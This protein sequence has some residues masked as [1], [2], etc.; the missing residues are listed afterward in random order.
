MIECVVQCGTDSTV[1][2]ARSPEGHSIRNVVLVMDGEGGGERDD[3]VLELFNSVLVW[4]L[5]QG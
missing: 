5:G 2:W 3:L 1:P 4:E